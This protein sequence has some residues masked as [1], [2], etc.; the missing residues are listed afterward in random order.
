ML[1]KQES[2]DSNISNTRSG[3]KGRCLS[4]FP[5]NAKN[6]LATAQATKGVPDSPTP[7]GDSED[8]IR[9]VSMVSGISSILSNW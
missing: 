8:F 3:V 9:L 1:L 6:A 7:C 4:L 5:V 2:Y